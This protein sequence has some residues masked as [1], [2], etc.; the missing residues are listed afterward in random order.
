MADEPD[1]KRARDTR[2]SD[3]ETYELGYLL[4]L[5]EGNRTCVTEPLP[6]NKIFGIGNTTLNFPMVEQNIWI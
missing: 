6:S 3:R 4:P 5:R 1:A 2:E